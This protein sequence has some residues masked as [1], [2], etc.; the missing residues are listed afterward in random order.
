M[1]KIYEVKRLT[2]PM[3]I[4]ADWEKPQWQ[5]VE[6]IKITNVLGAK[7]RFQPNV[8]A[9]LLYNTDYIYVIFRVEDRY[10]RAITTEN[11]GPVW[12]DSCVEFFFTPEM[13][14][15]KGYFNLETNCLGT[16]LFRH[17][18][19]PETN[20]KK[21]KPDEMAELEIAH[22]LTGE[23]IDPEITNPVTWTLEYHVPVNIIDRYHSV[24]KPSP[25][26]KWRANFF[27]CAENNSNPH[28]ITWSLIENGKLN[29]HQPEYFGIIEFVD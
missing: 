15:E 16:I 22:S 17:Q 26:V 13:E 6:P 24:V 11:H 19:K 4:D 5:N 9:K 2:V 3:P 21:L 20:T 27:K 8:Q 28:W 23:V 10:L 14:A 1:P 12:E 7:P 18:D 25:G 29:F